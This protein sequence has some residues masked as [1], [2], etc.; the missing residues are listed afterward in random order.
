L[1]YR[2]MDRSDEARAL[3]EALV[4]REDLDAALLPEAR[5]VLQELEAR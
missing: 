5:S 4:A 1:A 2:E 3:L